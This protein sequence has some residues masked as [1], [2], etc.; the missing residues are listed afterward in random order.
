[1]SANKE[2]IP[3]ARIVLL[4]A[5]SVGAKTSLALRFVQSTFDDHGSPTIGAAFIC[6][7]V[8][9]DG[10][11]VKLEMWGLHLNT[12]KDKKGDGKC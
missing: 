8:E 9:V 12:F 3:S 7:V 10:V 1:M 6:K 5:S 4:G 11:K 2:F